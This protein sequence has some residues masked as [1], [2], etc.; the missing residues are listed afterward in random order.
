MPSFSPHSQESQELQPPPAVAAQG[1][2]W[3]GPLTDCLKSGSRDTSGSPWAANNFTLTALNVPQISPI[4]S[5]A[6][7][8]ALSPYS[9][10]INQ[11]KYCWDLVLGPSPIC[12]WTLFCAFSALHP[13]LPNLFT[14]EVSQPLCPES[15]GAEGC[16]HRHAQ[17]RNSDS[18]Q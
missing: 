12:V 17:S 14:A 5:C 16:T 9:T 10:N 3:F 8:P 15:Y 1:F 18:H 7:S 4:H 6:S 2:H 13:S 11:S